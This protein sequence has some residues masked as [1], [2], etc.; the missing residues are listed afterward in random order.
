MP[1]YDGLPYFPVRPG[2]SLDIDAFLKVRAR[3]RR[4]AEMVGIGGVKDDAAALMVHALEAHVKG[5]LDGGARSRVGRDGL[6][7]H[8]NLVCGP[9]RG[10]DLREAALKN[11]GLLGDESGMELE[12][13][14][15]LL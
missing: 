6:R 13:L 15:M 11:L 5:L 1:T 8:G 4:V 2:R 12:R 10:Y 7:P 14:L 9:V 3:M